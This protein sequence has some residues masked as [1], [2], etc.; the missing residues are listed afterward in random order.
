MIKFY[1]KAD[2]L[3]LSEKPLFFSLCRSIS[4]SQSTRALAL[5]VLN[6]VCY[7]KDKFIHIFK[8]VLMVVALIKSSHPQNVTLYMF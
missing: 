1:G 5:N 6:A 3:L 4:V 8:T 7:Q 2:N